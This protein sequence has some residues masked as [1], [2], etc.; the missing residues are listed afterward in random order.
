MGWFWS[1]IPAPATTFSPKMVPVWGRDPE[2]GGP[3]WVFDPGTG[4]GWALHV[5]RGGR[6][7]CRM[8]VRRS[9]GGKFFLRKNLTGS[10]DRR[11]GCSLA[12]ACPTRLGFSLCVTPRQVW[13]APFVPDGLRGSPV[14]DPS[15]FD[16]Q[17]RCQESKLMLTKAN[18]DAELVG[19]GVG[20]E[21]ER[22][23]RVPARLLPPPVNRE[24]RKQPARGLGSRLSSS[25]RHCQAGILSPSFQTRQ[26]GAFLDPT[27]CQAEFMEAVTR[28]YGK[29]ITTLPC[30]RL[31]LKRAL[32]RSVAALPAWHGPLPD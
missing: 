7:G 16:W 10:P 28:H 1:Q 27:G 26:T 17:N 6:Q 29:K 2:G 22:R 30:Q 23:R 24:T 11:G 19:G 31:P 20:S 5:H 32:T 3:W 21:P 4:R 9:F 14:T 15:S 12:S 25:L 18:W 13:S 8:E